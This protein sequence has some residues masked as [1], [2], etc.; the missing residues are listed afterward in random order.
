MNI[1]I[2]NPSGTTI[3]KEY[4]KGTWRLRGSLAV[5]YPYP[6]GFIPGTLQEDG[7]PL[8]AF[9]I[10]AK[11]MKIKQGDV[12]DV[13]VL[14]MVEYFED[15]ERDSKI[16]VRNRSEKIGLQ[17]NRK[18][19]LS[20]FLLH[21]FDNQLGKKVKLSRFYGRAKAVNEIRNALTAD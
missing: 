14:G 12:V 18:A 2:E 7:D 20:N 9:L 8:D 4:D 6:Y 5:P 21:A 3:K 11:P 16:L 13:S 1:F 10:T 15:G 19:T 17:Q